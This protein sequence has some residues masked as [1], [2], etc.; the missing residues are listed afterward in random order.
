[1]PHFGRTRS[2][3]QVS[4]PVV[5]VSMTV[6]CPLWT[7]QRTQPSGASPMPISNSMSIQWFCNGARSTA[8]TS[9]LVSKTRISIFGTS[10]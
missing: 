5:V 2:N 8:P 4:T 10:P 6:S 1:M 7:T 9:V 3:S